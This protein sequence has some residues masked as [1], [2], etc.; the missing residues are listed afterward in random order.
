MKTLIEAFNGI[1]L[2][3]FAIGGLSAFLIQL[4]HLIFSELIE[5]WKEKKK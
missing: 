2:I 5:L 3:S 4:F 1:D